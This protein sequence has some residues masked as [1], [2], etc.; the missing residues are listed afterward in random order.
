MQTA[1]EDATSSTKGSAVREALIHG[2]PRLA[3][4]VDNFFKKLYQETNVR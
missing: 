1:L 3:A 2:Y 4:L